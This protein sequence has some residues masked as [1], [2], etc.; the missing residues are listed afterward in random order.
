MQQVPAIEPLI[1][2]CVTVTAPSIL[3]CSLSTKR[4]RFVTFG[5]HIADH[6]AINPQAATKIDVTDNAGS[7]SYKAVYPVAGFTRLSCRTSFRSSSLTGSDYR[8][9][10][11]LDLPILDKAGLDGLDNGTLAGNVITP[12]I[13]WKV[14]ERHAVGNLLRI[15]NLSARC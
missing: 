15:R 11:R 1:T 10:P 9:S 12:S 4:A 14:P 7:R 13:R 6:L 2:A 3:A 8:S 5:T